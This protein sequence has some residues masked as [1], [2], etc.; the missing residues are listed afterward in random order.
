[1]VLL[2]LAAGN[3]GQV[4][5]Q[6]PQLIG[7]HPFS[8]TRVVYNVLGDVDWPS[9][10][11][12]VG[13]DNYNQAQV[14]F[15]NNGW[16]TL[17]AP[18]PAGSTQVRPTTGSVTTSALSIQSQGGGIFWIG[19][20]AWGN[21]SLVARSGFWIP[22]G[23]DGKQCDYHYWRGS[24]DPSAARLIALFHLP[25]SQ[26]KTRLTFEMT[27]GIRVD[28]PQ[29][30]G[31]VFAVRPPFYINACRPREAPSRLVIGKMDFQS[32]AVRE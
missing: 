27:G 8:G 28:V 7:G 9:V 18:I 13:T 10:I 24:D 19:V 2:A 25:H 20:A 11:I 3:E 30:Q 31:Y 32:W 6:T 15:W 1:M 21:R 23:S 26:Y 5:A 17:G 14:F 22:S 12:Q 16:Q 29:G 4:S